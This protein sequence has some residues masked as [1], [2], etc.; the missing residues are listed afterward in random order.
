VVSSF[1][2]TSCND[3][4]AFNVTR[5]IKQT[6]L[7]VPEMERLPLFERAF[8]VPA[9]GKIAPDDQ[10]DLLMPSP[11]FKFS[12][13]LTCLENSI[14]EIAGMTSRLLGAEDVLSGLGYLARDIELAHGRPFLIT[15]VI[16]IV[17][18]LF[19]TAN[20][21]TVNRRLQCEVALCCLLSSFYG[22]GTI[23]TLFNTVLF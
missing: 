17:E 19:P 10:N 11:G 13:P 18:L 2:V 12:P 3:I 20:C 21:I 22:T 6:G 5:I 23:L 4:D 14:N 9:K 16:I 15:I 7:V 8:I 1:S